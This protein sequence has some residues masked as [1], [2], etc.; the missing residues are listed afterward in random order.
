MFRRAFTAIAVALASLAFAQAAQAG[1][2]NF[3]DRV[4]SDPDSYQTQPNAFTE[5]GLNFGGLQFYF[6]PKNNPDVT[7]PTS[8]DSTFMETAVEPVVVSLAGGGAFDMLSLDLGLGDYNQ[9]SSDTV[10]VTG[11][12]ANCATDC[13]VSTVLTVTNVFQTFSLTG[14]SDLASISFGAQQ[15]SNPDALF[16]PH[17]DSGYLAFDNIS[18]SAAVPEPASWGLM[19]LGFGAI[20]GLL[21][22][23]RLAAALTAT[24]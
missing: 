2:V 13:T 21:R 9:S 19:I 12:K 17:A 18:F 7:F 5:Q 15:F 22:G 23:R 11:T 1:V 6:I 20:G 16:P 24:A 14:F 4:F 3:E 8:Y 10:A